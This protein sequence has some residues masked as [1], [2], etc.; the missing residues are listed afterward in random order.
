[1]Y[2]QALQ[3]SDELKLDEVMCVEF[4]IA[5]AEEVRAQHAREHA[6]MLSGNLLFMLLPIMLGSC[7]LSTCGCRA[8]FE[9]G[10]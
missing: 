4:L 6:L 5:A 2:M 7:R 10:G 8:G 3:L 1:M 9:R